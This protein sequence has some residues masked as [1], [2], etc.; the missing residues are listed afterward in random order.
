M[1]KS[2][3]RLGSS[4]L[5][6]KQTSVHSFLKIGWQLHHEGPSGSLKGKDPNTPALHANGAHLWGKSVLSA[7][8]PTVKFDWIKRLHTVC[9]PINGLTSTLPMCFSVRFLVSRSF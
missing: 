5:G 6:A 4:T 9:T 3:L 2:K 1:D 8:Y 7:L